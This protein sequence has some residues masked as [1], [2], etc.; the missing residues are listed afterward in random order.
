MVGSLD[1]NSLLQYKPKNLNTFDNSKL[2]FKHEYDFNFPEIKTIIRNSFDN[3]N[4]DY[5]FLKNK[6]I[7]LVNKIKN[8]LGSLLVFGVKST[9]INVKFCNTKCNGCIVCKFLYTNDNIIINN[10][11]LPV[12]S[13]SNCESINSVYILFCLKC[14]AFYIGQTSKMIKIRI[15]QHIRDIKKFKLFQF[16]KPVALHFNLKGHNYNDDL[17]FFIFR[18]NLNHK[19]GRLN[20]ET[21]LIHFFLLLNV[22]ILNSFIPTLESIDR[23]DSLSNKKL[24]EII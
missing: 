3:I 14:N 2:L 16:D 12:L 10:F 11:N 13:N 7:S 17:R 23:F 4:S 5:I 24:F 15:Y 9:N 8:S 1:R 6:N 19:K 22:E 18:N 20:I 21:Q